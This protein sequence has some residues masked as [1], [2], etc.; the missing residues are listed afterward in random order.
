MMNRAQRY[1]NPIFILAAIVLF[2]VIWLGAYTLIN[3]G[4]EYARPPFQVL[5][6]TTTLSIQQIP[7]LI[8]Q[9]GEQVT[10][11]FFNPGF[12]KYKWWALVNVTVETKSWL[13][14]AN[15]HINDLRIYQEQAGHW[16]EMFVTGDYYP[17]HQ[18][19]LD[20]ADFWFPVEKGQ[21]RLLIRV[22]KQGE[23]LN[24]PLRL[25][26]ESQMQDYLAN[27][28]LI[29]GLFMGW[30]LMLVIMNM[31]LGISLKDRL[32]WF[33][34]GYVLCCFLWIYAQWGMGFKHLWPEATDF[35]SKSR[36][37]FSNLSFLF[38]LELTARFFTE[39]NSRR[40]YANT[41]RI[42]QGLLLFSTVG[43][44]MTNIPTSS[45]ALRYGYL[46]T[47]NIIWGM[48]MI[49]I[50]IL[51]WNGYRRQRMLAIYFLAA[52]GFYAMY[53]LLL[54]ASQYNVGGE[55]MYF[56]NRYGSPIG[57][58][59][60]ST[61][62][63]FGISQR[64]NYFKKEREV[65]MQALEKE[66][67]EAADRIIATQEA[68]RNRLAR[69]LHD[70]LGG[71]LGG[72]RIGADHRLR[73]HPEQQQW[74]GEQ[75]DLAIEDLRNIAHDLMPVQLQE[76]GL[77]KALEKTADRWRTSENGLQVIYN[78]H[79]SRRHPLQIEAAVYRIVLELMHN[80]KKHAGAKE[81]IVE[82]WEDE[83]TGKLTL[84]V[85]DDGIGFDAGTS[86]GMGWKSIRQRV[87]YMNGQLNLDTN[88]SGTTVII[89]IPME[90][91]S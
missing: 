11:G 74:I 1:K 62:L 89:E 43:M 19:L 3:D 82:I 56:I 4:K 77:D 54:L 41:I 85:Q 57:F 23:S 2:S 49:L 70:G 66:K 37:I 47:M 15:P 90:K 29:Y 46:T 52:M 6:D 69:E 16:R 39:P 75:L 7:E 14:I 17:Y 44:L 91:E 84:L 76:Q 20:D 48:A 27:K 78:S 83:R 28:N 13:H 8:A 36:P 10:D 86:E 40:L 32:H 81:L 61:I 25:I 53:V 80:V 42:T 45:V 51:I 12:T 5:P 64:Y 33:Y 34:I 18:R 59:G 72:I 73:P 65:A 68:E 35:T 87:R 50:I 55:L 21:G 9:K 31:F 88:T 71:L 67:R 63:S 30:T 24:L 58:L 79:I 26:A 22:D 60:E 38:L